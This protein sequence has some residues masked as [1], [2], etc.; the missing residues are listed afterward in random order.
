M[1]IKILPLIAISLM[2]ASC[3]T[4]RMTSESTKVEPQVYSYPTIADLHIAPQR[5]S[6]TV[7]WKWNP[8]N[9]TS[10]ATRRGNLKAELIQETGADILVEPEF[11]QRTSWCNL[12]GGSITVAGYP[13]KLDNFRKATPEDI[14]AMRCAG[15]MAGNE[16]YRYVVI[17]QDDVNGVVIGRTEAI[18]TGK[19]TENITSSI[20]EIPGDPVVV[21]TAQRPANNIQ[22][23]RTHT[24]Q[25]S[26]LSPTQTRRATLTPS[27]Y[28]KEG[29][30]AYDMIGKNR[31]LTTMA[32]EYYGNPDFW[33]YIYE[34][35]GFGHPDKIKPGTKV[36]IPSL[37]KYG[38]NPQSASDR[39]KAKRL[40]KEIYARYGKQI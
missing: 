22:T 20:E 32:R 31:F 4:V 10:L 7:K 39:E 18:P 21:E 11:T 36:V 5:T 19:N 40:A 2:A 12:A 14:E 6:K 27:N 3:S 13:A 34:E 8:F 15:M 28:K 35:N 16:P 29:P 33:P 37:N 30:I 38:V 26:S 1:K 17:G 24:Q 23:K 9:T 25:N